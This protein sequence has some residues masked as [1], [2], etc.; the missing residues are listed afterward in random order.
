MDKLSGVILAFA[1]FFTISVSA[2]NA[3]WYVATTA[4]PKAMP[5]AQTSTEIR[6]EDHKVYSYGIKWTSISP[7]GNSVNIVVEIPPARPSAKNGIPHGFVATHEPDM[8]AWYE[9]PTDRYQHGA[10]GDI[11]EAGRLAVRV[12]NKTLRL[13]LPVTQ[14]F[15]DIAPRLA[16]INGD[17][18]L[19]IVT[20]RSDLSTGAAIAVYAIVADEIVELVA[21]EPIGL[22]NRWLNIAGIADY[23]GDGALD[24]AQVIKPHL[25]GNLQVLTLRDGRLESYASLNGLSNHIN[26]DTELEMSATTDV[27]GDGIVDLVLPTFGQGS[28]VAYSFTNGINLLFRVKIPKRIRTAIGTIATESGPHFIFGNGADELQTVKSR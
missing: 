8:S 10:L 25:T 4:V 12:D 23:D 7:Q 22:A 28:L 26:G 19:D 17:G 18:N 16:D 14:V 2:A 24:I 20:I 9:S 6:Q 21:T 3:E 5:F 13:D 27:D 15:E 1:S 11:I